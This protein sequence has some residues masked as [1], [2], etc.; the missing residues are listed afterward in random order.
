MQITPDVIEEILVNE[1]KCFGL[2]SRF[3]FVKNNSSDK[4]MIIL[5]THNQKNS[6]FGVKKILSNFDTNILFLTDNNNSYYLENEENI[7]NTSYYK[8]L[9]G[10]V[11][12]YGSKNIFI[13]GSSMAGYAA[14]KYGTLFDLNIISFNPQLNIDI[15]Y[16]LAWGDLRKTFDNI[17]FFSPVSFNGFKG[18]LLCI[19]GYFPM[20][21]V[22]YDYLIKEAS[23]AG[24]SYI[25]QRIDTEEHNFYY[26]KN[27]S[28]IFCYAK[29]LDFLN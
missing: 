20:D 12:L 21:I 9:R 15:S 19:F 10:Y 1:V 23:Q 25:V 7:E 27:P 13:F 11:D 14:I 18:K 22:N 5:S 2:D 16:S 17:K 8:C 6:L 24:I 29:I 3:L 28:I 26:T 4:L